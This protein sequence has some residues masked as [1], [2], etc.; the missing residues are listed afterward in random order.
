MTPVTTTE[1]F[2]PGVNADCIHPGQ[3]PDVSEWKR[4][5]CPVWKGYFLL[6]SHTDAFEMQSEIWQQLI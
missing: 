1:S 5:F 2:G 4:F 3:K 6:L